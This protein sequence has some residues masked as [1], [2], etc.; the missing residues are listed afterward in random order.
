MDPAVSLRGG[1]LSVPAPRSSV[2]AA[3]VVM[4]ALKVVAPETVPPPS[5]KNELEV[6][7]VRVSVIVIAPDPTGTRTVAREIELFGVAGAVGETASVPAMIEK[8]TLSPDP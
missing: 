5:G 7:K 3:L 1:T 4:P 8:E 6:T 2:V